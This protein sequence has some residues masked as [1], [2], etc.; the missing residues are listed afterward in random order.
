MIKVSEHNMLYYANDLNLKY[1]LSLKMF[2]HIQR[3]G[4]RKNMELSWTRENFIINKKEVECSKQQQNIWIKAMT[5]NL[6]SSK[7][8]TWKSS[9]V[10]LGLSESANQMI[11]TYGPNKP[12]IRLHLCIVEEQIRNMNDSIDVFEQCI[13]STCLVISLVFSHI[14]NKTF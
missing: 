8:N 9:K 14:S 2:K 11:V 4:A 1:K 13:L 10:F 3:F 6:F 12:Q 7:W 5:G